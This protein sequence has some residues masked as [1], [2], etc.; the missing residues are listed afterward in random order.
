MLD[1]PRFWLLAVIVCGAFAVEATTGFGATVIAV[2]LGVHLFPLDELLPVIVPLGLFLSATIAWRERAYIDWPL[3]TRTILPL[4]GIGLLIG[5]AIFERASNEALRR[6]F[7]LFV[8]ILSA[9]ELWRRWAAPKKPPEPLPPLRTGATILGAG[10]IHGLFSSGGPLL[11]YALS[12]AQI[13]KRR[14]RATLSTVWLVMGSLL[15]LAYTLNGHLDADTLE[16]T[17]ALLPVL[18]IAWLAGDWLHHRLDEERFRVLVY[19][20][21]FVAGLTNLF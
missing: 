2:T 6:V 3:L 12:R 18:A 9:L 7:G 11:V 15:S 13:P 16:A 10:V 20:L 21:L 17:A 1:D 5:I 14:F 8:V 19:G 4:M